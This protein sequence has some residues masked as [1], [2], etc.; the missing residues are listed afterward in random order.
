MRKSL[1]IGL[2]ASHLMLLGVGFGTGV[3][4]LPVLTA[5]K[6]STKEEVNSVKNDA[7]YTGVFNKNQEGSNAVHWAEGQL[8]INDTDIAFEGSIAPGPDYKIYLTKVQANDR[9]SFLHI[10]ED[11][12]YIGDLKNFG[13]F[14]KSLPNGVN[15]DGYT[16]VQI[17]C[18]RFE[19]FIASASFK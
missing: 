5:E 16:T 12:L 3:Y 7:R 17:W 18:E 15:I 4:I 10:K 8:Y 14:K 19:Q 2:L 1:K 6:N 11:S 13:D 9:E